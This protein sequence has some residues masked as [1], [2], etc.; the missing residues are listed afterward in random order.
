M[1]E[2]CNFLSEIAKDYEFGFPFNSHKNKNSGFH[3][4]SPIVT[5]MGETFVDLEVYIMTNYTFIKI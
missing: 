4:I 5:F 1:R 2:T 3:E